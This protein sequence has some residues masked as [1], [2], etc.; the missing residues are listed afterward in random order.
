[1]EGATGGKA[2]SQEVIDHLSSKSDG[3]TLFV[4]ELT[5]MVVESGLVK[6]L[7]GRYEQSGSSLALKIPATLQ[8]SLTARLD[9]I[10][11]SVRWPN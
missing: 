8:D 6:E 7:D 5:K 9:R 11:L 2:M 1:M 4:E 10:P 3:L